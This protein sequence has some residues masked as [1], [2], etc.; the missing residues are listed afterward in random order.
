M[1]R[2]L[3]K[4]LIP[5]DNLIM[6]NELLAKEHKKNIKELEKKGVLLNKIIIGLDDAYCILLQKLR[7]L[8]DYEKKLR[9]KEVDILQNMYQ[10]MYNQ[11]SN[12]IE[13]SLKEQM[14]KAFGG[15]KVKLIIEEFKKGEINE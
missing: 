7:N 4:P 5:L 1:T 14:Q 12:H 9:I 6:K 13:N 10:Q 15:Y 3:K 2:K 11:I 8:H